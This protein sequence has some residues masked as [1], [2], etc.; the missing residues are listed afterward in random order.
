MAKTVA[1]TPLATKSA[2]NKGNGR[3]PNPKH[4]EMYQKMVTIPLTG[5]NPEQLQ[6]V[7]LA[8]HQAVANHEHVLGGKKKR[9]VFVGKTPSDTPKKIFDGTILP[10]SIS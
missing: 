6:A 7:A 5:A 2:I 4:I 10:D 8:A 3:K 9:S 1:R